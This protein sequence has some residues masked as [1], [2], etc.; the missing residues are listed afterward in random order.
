MLL[1]CLLF[2]SLDRMNNSPVWIL[3][4]LYLNCVVKTFSCY[5]AECLKVKRWKLL[6]FV[7]LFGTPWSGAQ[8]I[9]LSMELSSQEYRSGLLF[10]SLEVFPTQGSNQGLPQRICRQILYHLSQKGSPLNA[11]VVVKMFS[12]PYLAF[13]YPPVRKHSQIIAVAQ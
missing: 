5:F 6:S 13:F 8:Q 10:P 4:Y 1:W 12:C 9:P 3:I 7:Q 11:W 2:K